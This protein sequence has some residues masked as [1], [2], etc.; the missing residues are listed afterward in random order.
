[1]LWIRHGYGWI[2]SSVLSLVEDL[3]YELFCL[4]SI[5]NKRQITS[6]KVQLQTKRWYHI[7]VTHNTQRALSGGNTI[8]VY[9]DGELVASDRFRS[10]SLPACC[11]YNGFSVFLM[12]N[13]Y[14]LKNHVVYACPTSRLLLCAGVLFLFA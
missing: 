10:A 11:F 8:K 3:R 1:M 14:L 9:I 6:L 13:I 2:F 12:R 4:Q 7:C 5:S